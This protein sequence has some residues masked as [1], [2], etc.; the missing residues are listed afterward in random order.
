MTD[1]QIRE[2]LNHLRRSTR[3]LIRAGLNLTAYVEGV[4]NRGGGTKSAM[5]ALSGEFN[6]V[7]AEAS[8]L[9]R[10]YN[11]GLPADARDLNASR[12]DA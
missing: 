8:V 10:R 5:G 7:A 12:D 2:E 3:E 9:A 1:T 4:C 11:G 6:R